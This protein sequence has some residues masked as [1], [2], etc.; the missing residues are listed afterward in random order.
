[1]PKATILRVAVRDGRVAGRSGGATV[2]AA[3]IRTACAR[4]TNR[5]LTTPGISSSWRSTRQDRRPAGKRQSRI[6][7][8]LSV[9]ADR[10]RAGALTR[11]PARRCAAPPRARGHDLDRQEIIQPKRPRVLSARPR[12][13]AQAERRHH[14]PRSARH[15]ADHVGGRRSRRRRRRS[16]DGRHSSS[17]ISGRPRARLLLGVERGSRAPPAARRARSAR[18]S[19]RSAVEPVPSQRRLVADQLA[20]AAPAAPWLLTGGFFALL[21]RGARPWARPATFRWSQ[22]YPLAER[23]AT[24]PPTEILSQDTQLDSRADPLLEIRPRSTLFA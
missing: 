12:S 17:P 5:P 22:G 13:P 19:G 14:L 9:Q 24:S 18:R 11:R 6:S 8:P 2:F 15:A 4:P 7:F 1:M 23:D 21:T 20:A 16:V 3:P 10:N